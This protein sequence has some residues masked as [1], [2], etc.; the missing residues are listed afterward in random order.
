MTDTTYPVGLVMAAVGV[1]FPDSSFRAPAGADRC[2]LADVHD[3][4]G[5]SAA[6]H[7]QRL[8][9]S[10]AEDEDEDDED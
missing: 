7:L 5:R 2:T 9:A 4:D 1:A 8:L 3:Q 6:E 10:M